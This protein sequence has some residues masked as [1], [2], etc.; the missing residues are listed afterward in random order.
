VILAVETKASEQ[1]RG[2]LHAIGEE[3]AVAQTRL[4]IKTGARASA[5]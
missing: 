2:L 1:L 3:P 5:Y 4:A